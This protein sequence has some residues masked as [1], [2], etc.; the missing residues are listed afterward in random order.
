MTGRH[1]TTLTLTQYDGAGVPTAMV[2][3][4]DAIVTNWAVGG[5]N[6]SLD[7]S[8]EVRVAFAKFTLTDTASGNR[9]CWDPVQGRAC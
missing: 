4:N 1:F 3:L 9:F 5:S 2:L 7:A 6:T 8:E